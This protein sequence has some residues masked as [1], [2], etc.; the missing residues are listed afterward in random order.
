M[1]QQVPK[2]EFIVEGE[3]RPQPRPTANARGKFVRMIAT[4]AQSPCAPFKENLNLMARQHMAAVGAQAMLGP[5]F[6]EIDCVWKRPG[7]LKKID[8][9]QRIWR[10]TEKRDDWDN[11]AKSVCDAIN[12]V[13]YVDDSQIVGGTVRKFYGRAGEA[14]HVRIVLRSLLV[15]EA[16]SGG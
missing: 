4:P 8:P 14:A 7:K 13:V 5:I 6:I 9:E 12:G 11:L 1:R 10:V 2:I 16:G 3:P 15:R